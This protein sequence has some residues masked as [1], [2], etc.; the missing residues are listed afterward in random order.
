MNKESIVI[1]LSIDN[2]TEGVYALSALKN[3]TGEQP[4]LLQRRNAP[5]LRRHLRDLCAEMLASL[6]PW[7]ISTNIT[8][9]ESSHIMVE[10][11]ALPCPAEVMLSHMEAALT[12]EIITSA[13]GSAGKG[14][15]ILKI[16]ELFSSLVPSPLPRIKRA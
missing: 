11:S 5:A 14:E 7:V 13:Y 10:F 9:I 8:D 6:T 16:T 4:V 3:H 2:V 15:A 12:A 1:S